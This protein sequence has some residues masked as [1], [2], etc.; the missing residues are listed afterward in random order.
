[1]AWLAEL[2]LFL[3]PFFIYALWRRLNPGIEPGPRLLIAFAAGLIFALAAALWYGF[4]RSMDAS[5]RYVPPRF[6]DGRLVPGHAE[7]RP[8]R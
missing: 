3:L 1:M 2:F 7:P 8:G 6:E 4:S 5:D